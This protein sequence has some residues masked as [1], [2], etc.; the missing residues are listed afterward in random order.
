VGKSG[1]TMMTSTV[2]GLFRDDPQL[3]TDMI[4]LMLLGRR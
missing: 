2:R 4:S 3:G 1:S